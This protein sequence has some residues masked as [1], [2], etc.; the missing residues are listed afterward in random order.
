M[1]TQKRANDVLIEVTGADLTT[2]QNLEVCIRQGE[3]ERSYEVRVVSETELS[4]RIPYEDAMLINLG[5][6]NLQLLFCWSDGTP[7]NSPVL[8]VNT[9]ELLPTAGYKGAG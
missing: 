8:R 3:F 1:I 7:D 2:L 6:L 9:Q 4:F 5:A